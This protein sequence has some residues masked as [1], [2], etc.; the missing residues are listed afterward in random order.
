[1]DREDEGARS[2]DVAPA[3]L[4]YEKGSFTLGQLIAQTV[5]FA[6]LWAVMS[7]VG[8][9]LFIYL[10]G[11]GDGYFLLW[12]DDF[13]WLWPNIRGLGGFVGVSA[14]AYFGGAALWN[15][16]RLWKAEGWSPRV[17]GNIVLGV[18]TLVPAFGILLWAILKGLGLI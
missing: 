8:S 7:V 18:M 2:E 15:S 11:D 14:L 16:Q 12:R 3:F 5:L 4:D 13:V 1:M 6:V 10:F 9:Y 17:L